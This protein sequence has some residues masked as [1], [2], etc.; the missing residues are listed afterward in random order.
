MPISNGKYV[1]PTWVNGSSP[2]IDATELQ[3]MSDSIEANQNSRGLNLI[4]SSAVTDSFSV[5]TK[6]SGNES[7]SIN[8]IAYGDGV[9][10]AVAGSYGIVYCANGFDWLVTTQSGKPSGTLNDITY[11]NGM[12]VAVGDSDIISFTDPTGTWT[13][14]TK[15][16][17]VGTIYAVAYFSNYWFIGGS[18]G[19]YRSSE[20]NSWTQLR[21]AACCDFDISYSR[22]YA[23]SS[24][25]VKYTTSGSSWSSISNSPTPVKKIGVSPN[26]TTRTF[27][28]IA[29]S[30]D[31]QAAYYYNGSTWA[32]Y[33]NPSANYCTFTDCAMLGDDKYISMQ[34][35]D[36]EDSTVKYGKVLKNPFTSNSSGTGSSTAKYIDIYGGT[37]T[38]ITCAKV[39]NN[40]LCFG[41]PYGTVIRNVVTGEVASASGRAVIPQFYDN[42]ILANYITDVQYSHIPDNDDTPTEYLGGMMETYLDGHVV[43]HLRGSFDPSGKGATYSRTYTMSAPIS[44]SRDDY[45]YC[46]TATVTSGRPTGEN[47]F[48]GES[49]IADVT[50][51]N[52]VAVAVST[53]DG[54]TLANAFGSSY[55]RFSLHIVYMPRDKSAIS[56]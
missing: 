15:P 24:D 11:G 35:T 1:A 21:S 4:E 18:G 42:A 12:F 19:I 48:A 55:V 22:L 14:R 8:G 40:E 26:T 25:G 53:T 50:G 44:V 16:S 13:S 30:D 17:G 38:K 39:I 27:I 2:A 31:S 49:I 47:Y 7:A 23:A 3:A 43:L 33:S 32:T 37:V 6:L 20:L 56:Y 36:T 51:D 29:G 46:L 28:A 5:L 45:F 52:T 41:A 54:T 9:I 34:W 10:C